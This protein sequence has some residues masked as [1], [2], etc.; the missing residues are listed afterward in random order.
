M[1]QSTA[2][3]GTLLMSLFGSTTSHTEWLAADRARTVIAHEWRMLFREW[4]VVLCPAAPTVA[5][6]HDHAE[7]SR[8]KLLIDDKPIAYTELPLWGA[9]ATLCGLPATCMPIGLSNGLPI[10]LQIIGPH[11]EDRTTIGFADLAERELGGFVPP[12]SLSRDTQA[13]RC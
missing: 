7:M 9:L 11:L 6:P 3:F 5:F 13:R 10:G 1:R 12:P 8:R 4:D 2:L